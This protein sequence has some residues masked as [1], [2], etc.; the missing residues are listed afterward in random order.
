MGEPTP[1]L[2]VDM[3]A[4]FAAVEVVRR[5]ELRGLPV[6]VGGEGERSVVAAASYEARGYGLPSAQPP[7][8]GQRP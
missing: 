2:H 8:G 5:P 6:V 3:D 4:F 1:I 7:T